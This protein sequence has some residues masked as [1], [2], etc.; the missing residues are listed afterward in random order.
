MAEVKIEKKVTKTP[1]KKVSDIHIKKMGNG[2]HVRHE[3]DPEM[4]RIPGGGQMPVHGAS[5]EPMVFSGAKA[6]KMMLAHVGNLSDQMGLGIGAG[7]GDGGGEG[8]NVA[9]AAQPAAVTGA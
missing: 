2:Y 1:T 3:H 7:T 4:K 9:G 8:G 5:P 6:K